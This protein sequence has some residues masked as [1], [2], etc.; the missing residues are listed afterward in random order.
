MHSPSGGLYL[1]NAELS[2]RRFLRLRDLILARSGI[3]A[4]EVAHALDCA[5]CSRGIDLGGVGDHTCHALVVPSNVSLLR[6]PP[7]SPELN[8][9]ENLWH[10]LRLHYWLKWVYPDWESLK[11]AVVYGMRSV[12]TD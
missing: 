3:M 1:T 4:F 12:G 8:P 6:L 7:Y 5:R 10:D 11:E 9:I 2:E